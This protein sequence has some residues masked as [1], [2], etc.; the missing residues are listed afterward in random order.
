MCQNIYNLWQKK[1]LKTFIARSHKN[2]VCWPVS[3]LCAP[4]QTCESGK[5]VRKLQ[6]NQPFHGIVELEESSK[7]GQ[8]SLTLLRRSK[9]CRAG[10]STV[11]SHLDTSVASRPNTEGTFS[12]GPKP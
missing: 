8:R 1:F 2:K 10:F 9:I 5:K 11:C 6:I 12:L 7:H 4:K 3:T